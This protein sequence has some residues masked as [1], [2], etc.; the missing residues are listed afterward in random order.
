MSVQSSAHVIV[1]KEIR[2]GKASERSER[3]ASPG[4][5]RF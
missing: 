2:A 3:G 5:R 4:E 1:Q